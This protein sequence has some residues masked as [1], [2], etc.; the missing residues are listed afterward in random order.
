[1]AKTITLR[2]IETGEVLYPDVLVTNAYDSE[3]N[4]LVSVLSKKADLVDGVVP[5]SQLPAGISTGS[6][7]K[8]V[9]V[10]G[11][12]GSVS[13]SGTASVVVSAN[14]INI[15][16]EYSSP[17]SI[18]TGYVKIPEGSTI[19]SALSTLEGNAAKNKKRINEL[20]NIIGIVSGEDGYSPGTGTTYIKDAESL[21][22]AVDI[23]DSSLKSERAYVDEKL[24]DIRVGSANKVDN[25]L[26]LKVDSGTTEDKDLYT[27]DGSEVKTINFVS[28]DNISLTTKNGEIIISG[29]YLVATEDA[30][31]LMSANDKTKLDNIDENANYYTHP[32]HTKKV[33][34]LYKITVNSL[35]HV[36]A[37]TAV[38]AD[39]IVALGIPAED[40]H[41]ESKNVVSGTAT[42]KTNTTIAQE[43][44]NVY[45]NSV[46][47]DTVTSSHKIYGSGDTIVT[48]DSSGNIKITSQSNSY[49]SLSV[50]EIKT[51]TNTTGK[52]ISASVFKSAVL[53]NLVP[54]FDGTNSGRVKKPATT[55]EKSMFLK[56]DG[57][58][59]NPEYTDR[60]VTE[61]QFHYTPTGDEDSEL[62]V[63]ANG[64]SN[65]A[66]WNITSLV[67]GVTISRDSKGHVTDLTVDSV[68]MPGNPNVNTDSKVAQTSKSDSK[69]YPILA[70]SQ[71]TSDTL[72]SGNAYGA[73]FNSGITI[74]P[75]TKTIKA[76]NFLGATSTNSIEGVEFN[77]TESITHYATCSTS[78]G[79]AAKTV[80][81][82]GFNLDTGSRI[83]IKFTTGNT[84]TNPT[85]NING[86]GAKAIRYRGSAI[87]KS[88]IATNGVYEFVF[89]GTYYNVVGDIN[90]D[91]NT[92][93][94][95]DRGISLVDGKFGHENSLESIISTLP[96]NSTDPVSSNGGS[97]TVTDF[98]YDSYGHV[99]GS[100]ERTITLS[101]PHKGTVTSVTIS[102]GDGITVTN[103]SDST[104]RSST[105]ITGSGTRKIA[106][107]GATTDTLGGI[108]LY[109][110]KG[111]SSVVPSNENR[112]Y[113]VKLDSNSKAYVSVPWVNNNDDTKNT[114]GTTEKTG[115]KLFLVGATS[116]STSTG[117]SGVTYTNSGVY[118]G[119]NNCLYSGGFI[120]SV[121]GHEHSQYLTELPSHSHP[122]SELTGSTTTANQAIVSSGTANKWKLLTLGAAAEYGVSTSITSK[123]TNSNL[124]TSKAVYD[125]ITSGIRANDAMVFKGVVNSNSDL[126]V[127]HEVGDT[128]RVGT[129]GT[130]AGEGC[131][132]GDLIICIT[133]GSGSYNSHWII[134]QANLDGTVISGNG[135]NPSGLDGKVA[136]YSG[137]TGRVISASAYKL[138]IAT[139]ND[140]GLIK[141]VKSYTTAI[142]TN[143][144]SSTEGRYY[145]VEVDS[146]GKAFVNVPWVQGASYTLLTASDSVLG[147]IKT[148]Y[149]STTKT[150]LPVYVSS[151]SKAYVAVTKDS[152]INALGYT[153]LESCT[154]TDEKVKHTVSS[155][156]SDFPI[157]A[158]E[159]T[160]PTTNTAYSAIYDTSISIN[161]YTNTINADIFNGLAKVANSVRVATTNSA[162]AS[163]LYPIWT[164]GMT[165]DVDYTLRAN[166]TFT[167]LLTQGTTSVIGYATL[168]LGNSTAT[169]TA[170]NSSG[171]LRLYSKNSYYHEII[172][173]NATAT[174]SHT[175][176]DI[177]GTL[178]NTG[179]ASFTRSY[180]SG[181]KIGS[182][183]LG[184]STIDVYIPSYPTIPTIPDVVV[185][186]DGTTSGT[187]IT[188][189]SVDTTNKHKIL[190]SRGDV[191]L[192][193][194]G[195][196]SKSKSFALSTSW[197]TFYT[198]SEL[199]SLSAG[200]YLIQIYGSGIGY[201]SGIMSWDTSGSSD[202][203][204]L[205]HRTG[206][207]TSVYAKLS[208][209]NLQLAASGSLSSR[210][211]K[212]TF[213]KLI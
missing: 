2:D 37:A 184:G 81:K 15:S 38:T 54:T 42:G 10:N 126:S 207:S 173:D 76:D 169:G 80:S 125:A 44:G 4:N 145:A 82:D 57:S 141:P 109:N 24:E 119:S 210:T 133:K 137:N 102:A 110:S 192:V 188:G 146:G 121:E 43:N 32:T 52:V 194:I 39:D 8:G 148:G 64:G 120:V 88:Y 85:L 46:E 12:S 162:V 167:Y 212:V 197:T 105:A 111:T 131:E 55:N 79:T 117:G 92:T 96:T 84:A 159:K 40:T 50:S 1:M 89:D 185:T 118:I 128:Y 201:S 61:E 123:S 202:D 5:L 166:N 22:E 68:K 206:A 59:A 168:S 122:Y 56:G 170:N 104:D 176:P 155:T 144:I 11:V 28:G 65:Y 196:T 138:T 113:D 23:L 172:A 190:V 152:V 181:T 164:S 106:I 29:D 47:N 139:S 174:R 20:N 187:F 17:T 26:I 51:G 198:A 127:S 75:E 36:T 161:P 98:T 116:Q 149:T 6:G 45:L 99:T 147:G 93:Y 114:T 140:A 13:A 165:A 157:L 34:G 191:S 175:L 14:D 177:G 132:I 94:G 153:P 171:R 134:V 179:N 53:D 209:R 195:N 31:G 203:E 101:E 142:T 48:T 83:I 97:F 129:K 16:E 3:G 7:I 70:S 130:Y 60:S 58:W 25:D 135:E 160:S 136:I 186:G 67:T 27:F 211:I 66:S 78:A 71:S 182:I 33:S 178:L 91:S 108:K 63:D 107:K 154:N 103:G 156:N 77:N 100:Q 163:P 41:Y 115:T 73:S 158:S 69:E 72:T 49:D 208:S 199:S 150:H 30:A 21:K 87:N 205:L 200:T 35:G 193:G 19:E 124:P 213:K 90:T 86:T 9:T 112:T 62:D 151:S 143:A 189:L 18:P 183:K 74:I 95:S 180:D 204:I